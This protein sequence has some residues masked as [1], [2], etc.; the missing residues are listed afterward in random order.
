MSSP[1]L[2]APNR[3][4]I[5]SIQFNEAGLSTLRS[6]LGDG[7]VYQQ[8]KCRFTSADFTWFASGMSQVDLDFLHNSFHRLWAIARETSGLMPNE[9]NRIRTNLRSELKTLLF[10]MAALLDKVQGGNTLILHTDG[11][12]RPG[13]PVDLTTIKVDIHILP[14]MLQRRPGVDVVAQL[15]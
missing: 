3:V 12:V 2:T 14:H 13:K 4:S 11:T 5:S 7:T 8:F 9:R 15:V 6:F 1:R 10:D